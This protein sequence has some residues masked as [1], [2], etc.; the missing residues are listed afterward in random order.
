MGSPTHYACCKKEM[1]GR[2]R[3]KMAILEL[4]VGGGRFSASD[5]TTARN[6]SS[7]SL[8]TDS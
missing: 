3:E 7:N 2:I 6:A 8:V 5:S 4:A 1:L